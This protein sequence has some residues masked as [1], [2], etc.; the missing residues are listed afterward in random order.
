MKILRNKPLF[1]KGDVLIGNTK[2]SRWLK[3]LKFKVSKHTE[4]R[5]YSR[6]GGVFR[7]EDFDC[8]ICTGNTIVSESGPV[9]HDIYGDFVKEGREKERR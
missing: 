6:S 3:G 4:C 7:E 8:L 2:K 9:F 1:K 5:W